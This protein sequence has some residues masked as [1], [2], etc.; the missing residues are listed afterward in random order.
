MVTQ[1]RGSASLWFGGTWW[2]HGAEEWLQLLEELL[3][4]GVDE[5]THVVEEGLVAVPGVGDFEPEIGVVG[6]AQQR[7]NDGSGIEALHPRAKGS[8]LGAVEGD[9][10]VEFP[11]SLKLEALSTMLHWLEPS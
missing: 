9:D 5:S 4:S 11:Q 3:A 8:L 6:E 7:P 2:V 1:A 10:E